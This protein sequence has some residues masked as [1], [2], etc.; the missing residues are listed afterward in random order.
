M[1]VD[2]L[3]RRIK[4]VLALAAWSLL[5]GLHGTA[6]AQAVIVGILEGRVTLLRPAGKLE[7][8]EG[9]MLREADI[10]ETA[11]AAF[12]QL[13]LADGVRVGLGESSRLVLAPAVAPAGSARPRAHLL[14][15]WMKL[16]PGAEKTAG[17]FWTPRITI[18][19]L[20]G[21]CVLNA[22][23]ARFALFVENGSITFA[24]RGKGSPQ[25]QPAKAGDFVSGRAGAALG[26]AARPEADFIERMPRLF[27]DALP[28]RAARWRDRP[29]APRA[30]GDAGYDDVAVWLQAEAAIRVPM[31]EAWRVRLA[32]KAFRDAVLA[33]L[34]Q[35]PEW[36]PLVIPP[37]KPE[38]RPRSIDNEADRVPAQPAVPMAASAPP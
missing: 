18:G 3:Y 34:P 23:A 22:E 1:A 38:P 2:T 11:P 33:H 31:I 15:G 32:D 5:A 37:K 21:T 13:E 10:V 8:A 4:R 16:T 17:E 27:R 26:T 35:H 20:A 14:Q 7:L 36:R 19:S 28:A 29:A 12:V 30:L 24:E 9:V 6:A 25:H